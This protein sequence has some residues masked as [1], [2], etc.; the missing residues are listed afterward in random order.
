[1][2]LPAATEVDVRPR[3]GVAQGSTSDVVADRAQHIA[4]RLLFARSQRGKYRQALRRHL[5]ELV[6]VTAIGT[7]A[8]V[9]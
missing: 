8:D 6:M 1:V 9:K 4:K 7:I 3:A 2:N 5:D